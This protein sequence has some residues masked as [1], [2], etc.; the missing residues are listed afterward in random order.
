[1]I[2][3]MLSL[4]YHYNHIHISSGGGKREA[5]SVVWCV[6]GTFAPFYFFYAYIVSILKDGT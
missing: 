6:W 1:M 4:V 2:N 5:L 3:V